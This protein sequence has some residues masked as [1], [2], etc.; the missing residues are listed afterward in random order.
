MS[1]HF[2]P[3]ALESRR[4]LTHL[5]STTQKLL[6]RTTQTLISFGR[7]A[8]RF[9]PF[10]GHFQTLLCS[11]LVA[12]KNCY[13][14]EETIHQFLVRAALECHFVQISIL[15]TKLSAM[16]L[17]QLNILG[18]VL[19]M[20]KVSMEGKNKI[21]IHEKQLPHTR[22]DCNSLLRLRWS[23]LCQTF[24]QLFQHV[25]FK[26]VQGLA[27]NVSQLSLN[28]QRELNNVVGRVTAPEQ[29]FPP[30]AKEAV[31]LVHLD[32]KIMLYD[33]VST[34]RICDNEVFHTFGRPKPCSE[35]WKRKFCTDWRNSGPF[36][37]WI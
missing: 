22:P 25:M 34:R 1:V 12:V 8:A 31:H 3:I 4:V 18:G 26:R 29:G 35:Y 27:S 15:T 16:R 36:S 5:L 30:K 33:S 11:K 9:Q 6:S 13:E 20:T 7:H 28:R 24:V 10:H 2:I 14:G 21:P 19:E 17:T 37:N 32:H 23:L